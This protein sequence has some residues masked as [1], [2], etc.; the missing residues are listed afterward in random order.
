MVEM[1]APSVQDLHPHP[2]FCC[3]AL[4]EPAMQIS[5]KTRSD[6][7]CLAA[8]DGHPLAKHNFMARTHDSISNLN[9]V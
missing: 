7:L 6:M 3:P 9:Q 4:C 8:E 1:Q 5:G 2:A